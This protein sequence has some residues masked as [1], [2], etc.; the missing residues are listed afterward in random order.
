[1]GR[2]ESEAGPESPTRPPTPH[3][4]A[5]APPAPPPN[6]RCPPAT[7]R[8][9]STE[10]KRCEGSHL[11]PEAQQGGEEAGQVVR[12]DVPEERGQLGRV[13]E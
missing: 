6:A 13:P 2:T 3:L 11:W 7:P 5:P 8:S 12:G 10:G 4:H 1:M 9:S